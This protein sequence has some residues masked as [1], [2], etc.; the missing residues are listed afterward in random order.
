[1]PASTI[2]I[3]ALTGQDARQQSGVLADILIACV[4]TGAS[5]SFMAPLAHEK[6]VSFWHGVAEAIGRAECNL[7][8]AK[9][10][11][12]GQIL[13]TVQV[14]LSHP[15]NQPHR[16]EVAKMLVHP[17]ARHRGIGSQLMRAVEGAAR[18]AGKTLL[19]LDA[20]TG[21]NAERLYAHLGWI[22][23]GTIPDYALWPDGR[24]CSTTIFY[25]RI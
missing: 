16:G 1:M 19:V 4:H 25:K 21:G 3:V 2:E 10:L 8:V 5:V 24:P 13:G 18:A 17:A 6:A 9:E 22:Q 20:A 15:E 14:R 12:T 11:R 7:L 23:V